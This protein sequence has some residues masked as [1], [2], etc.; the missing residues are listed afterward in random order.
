[1]LNRNK[2]VWNVAYDGL[3]SFKGVNGQSEHTGAALQWGGPK[4]PQPPG[5]GLRGLP[6]E[7]A[8]SCWRPQR[9]S[10]TKPKQRGLPGSCCAAG[11]RG[12]RLRLRAGTGH[13][14]SVSSTKGYAC[15]CKYFREIQ[16]YGCLLMWKKNVPDFWSALIPCWS[17]DCN[18]QIPLP[19]WLAQITRVCLLNSVVMFSSW[20]ANL[21]KLLK[22][23]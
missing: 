23:R 2:N 4:L 13:Q 18:Y 11:S 15:F 21:H 17:Q 14:C 1:M 20:D 5:P 16:F 10:G 12:R 7:S 9:P 8:G 19:S 6:E 22:V 3:L